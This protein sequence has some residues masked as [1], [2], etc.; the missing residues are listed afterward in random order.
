MKIPFSKIY[1]TGLEF[2]YMQDCLLRGEIAGNGYYT[3]RAQEYMQA[4]F[5]SPKVLLTT[6]GTA[7]L[8]MAALLINLGPGDEVI[9]PSFTFVSTANAVMLRGVRPIFVDIDRKTLNIDTE[10][11][12]SRINQ[13]TK[14]IIPV[15]YAGLACDMDN[16]MD[17]AYKNN[18]YVIEDA[19]QAVNSTY[20]DKYLGTLGHIG[21]YSFHG[22]KNYVC[23]EGG[24]LLLNIDSQQLLDRAE[25][26]W[27]KGTNRNQFLRG[28]ADKYT[29]VDIG[30]SY[31]PA[32]ILAA[33]LCAQLEEI[34]QITVQ[35]QN[36]YKYYYDS[37]RKYHLAGLIRLP[38][39]PDECQS[40]YHIFYCLFNSTSQR[41]YVMYALRSRGIQASFHYI[42]LHSSPMGKKL[43]YEAD[44]LPVT[45]EVSSNL[46]RL[47]IYPQMTLEEQKYVVESL[48]NILDR[49]N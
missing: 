2:K 41:D 3:Q 49:I 11:I 32:D 17:L 38:L 23:G 12:K 1:T 40:N 8:E 21:C 43:G 14:A 37:L 16:I 36:I 31:L 27:E 4:K 9:M 34:D 44:D 25:L 45:E 13:N 48:K 5:G 6:S 26:I 42:P 35:R 18:L 29:W 47:P 28:Q 7:A 46:L 30:S 24:A 20:K 22:T 19:A 15:H 39:I 10:A 33:L